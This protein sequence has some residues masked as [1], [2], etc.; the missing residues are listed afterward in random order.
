MGTC[1]LVRLRGIL[2]II[3]M[4]KRP[5][6]RPLWHILGWSGTRAR[7]YIIYIFSNNPIVAPFLTPPILTVFQC[8]Q[9]VKSVR[10]PPPTSW[11]PL[12]TRN[13]HDTPKTG[14]LEA[15]ET[16]KTDPAVA[17]SLARRQ[18]KEVALFNCAYA[19]KTRQFQEKVFE[20][21]T[22]SKLRENRRKSKLE[23]TS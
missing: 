6:C 7:L 13:S 4:S 1:K 3:Q 18:A 10:P 2:N 20:H 12:N 22:C 21:L 16:L 23:R 17:K 15:L 9:L 14:V 19:I 5:Q 8:Y 11:M